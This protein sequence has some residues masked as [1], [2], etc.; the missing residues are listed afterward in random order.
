M[1]IKE[2]IALQ[3]F[4]LLVVCLCVG[5]FHTHTILSKAIQGVTAMLN[6]E[7]QCWEYH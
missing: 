1:N 6:A 3:Y 2:K 4:H 7:A 5:L